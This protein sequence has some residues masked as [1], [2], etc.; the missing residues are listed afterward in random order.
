[1]GAC[2]AVNE[3]PNYMTYPAREATSSA[4]MGVVGK[5]A[6]VAP[7][8]TGGVKP[9]RIAILGLGIWI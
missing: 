7:V 1:M 4:I 5:Q 2:P 3:L 9:L 6:L 8:E